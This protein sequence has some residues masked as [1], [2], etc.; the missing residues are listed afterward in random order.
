M[1][2]S[3]YSNR[4]YSTVCAVEVDAPAEV[5]DTILARFIHDFQTNPD[6]LF[7]WAFYGVGAQKEQERN[8]FLIEYKST[9]YIP[10]REYGNVLIDV[11]IP[12]ITRFED[13]LLEGK[14]VDEHQTIQYNPNLLID[15]LTA[16]NIPNWNRYVKIDVKYTGRLL[17]YGY[18]NLYI[19][20]VDATH[21]VFF[22]DMNLKYGW[23]FNV[24][25]TMK[26]YRNSVEWRINRYMHNLKKVAEELYNDM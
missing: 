10:E 8:A 5:S 6:A 3:M 19:L 18:G 17:D 26:M 21:S 11:V 2:V 24:F 22:M 16:D 15:T 4:M 12:G 20:P 14:V 1:I 9:T 23:F 25:I 7:D 13:I